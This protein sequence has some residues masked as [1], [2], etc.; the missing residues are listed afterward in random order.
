MVRGYLELVRHDGN[1]QLFFAIEA[2]IVAASAGLPLHI[3][4]EGLRGTGKTTIMRAARGILPRIERIRGCPYNCHPDAPHCPI[5]RG[6]LREELEGIG[7][8]FIPMPF[9]EISHSAKVGTVVGT[10]DL[11]RITDPREPRAALLPGILPR[12]HR[13]IVFIDEINRLADTS[14]ELTDI[15]LDVMGTKPGRLQV[16]EAGL[17]PFD[18]PLSVSVWAAS[19]PDEDPGPLEEVRRQLAD[20]FDMV[21]AMGRPREASVIRNMMFEKAPLGEP[22]G[23]EEPDA[24]ALE[25]ANRLGRAG[26]AYLASTFP[27]QLME[28]LASMYVDYGIESLRAVESACL[29]VRAAAA[30]AG[31]ASPG[32]EELRRVLPLV[33][34]HRAP[35]NV[36]ESIMR[37]LDEHSG[38]K[39]SQTGGN[40]G[41]SENSASSSGNPGLPF[42]PMPPSSGDLAEREG[43]PGSLASFLEAFLGRLKDLFSRRS[44]PVSR[45][46]PMGAPGMDLTRHALD[47][48][49]IEAVAPP[50]PAR[51]ISILPLTAILASEEDLRR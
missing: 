4:A 2:S 43:A 37:M 17:L 11:A 24:A 12:A 27:D 39:L 13:G 33:L 42:E 40:P 48:R 35:D 28:L 1:S 41:R 9:L 30:L 18:I 34:R 15:L 31:K 16:E 50:K 25:L 23:S 38:E 20:R 26:S 7:R 45:Q 32:I 5:H 22:A 46:A 8:E 21:V 49:V 19:N 10:I 51:P 44:P 47:D 3:H 14:P 36:R 6:L 29:G